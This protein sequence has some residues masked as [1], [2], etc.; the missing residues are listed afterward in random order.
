[1]RQFAVFCIVALCISTSFA[2]QS[3]KPSLASIQKFEAAKAKKGTWTSIYLKLAQLNAKAGGPVDQLIESLQ[4]IIN[5]LD[6][7]QE[8][9]QEQFDARTV[10]HNNEVKRLNGE[11]DDANADISRTQA[12]LADVLYVMKAEFEAEIESLETGIANAE[13]YVAEITTTREREHEEFQTKISEHEG[14]IAAIE[15][16]L[17]LLA[18]LHGDPEGGLSL[19]QVKKA[20]AALNKASSKL[21]KSANN[22]LVR[23]LV[24]LATEDFAN[25]DALGKIEDMMVEV[26]QNLEDN[27]VRFTEEEEQAQTAFD[28]EV[29]QKEAEINS[30]NV[31]LLEK[32]GQLDATNNKIEE[33]QNFIVIRQGDVVSYTSELEA[34]EHSYEVDT[35]NYN[36]LMAEFQREQDACH[37]A[38]AILESA[39]FAGYLDERLGMDTVIDQP[40]GDV[41]VNF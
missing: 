35:E 24:Q 22:A 4:K 11:V 37:E 41:P 19:V 8:S 18:T 25:Q 7:K 34:E 23:A 21:Q 39:E 40:Q 12:F 28:D 6:T 36:D 20:K 29:A 3:R 14:A 13:A 27:I 32:N 2:I 5:D 31:E 17:G 26:K 38:L 33:N 15:E 10:D 9:A 30:M 1:M 16:C